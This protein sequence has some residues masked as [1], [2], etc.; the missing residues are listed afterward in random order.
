MAITA[1]FSPGTGVLSLVGDTGSSSGDN[2]RL[3]WNRG[4]GSDVM[5][6]GADI[7]AAPFDGGIGCD[8]FTITA[9]AGRVR[10]FRAFRDQ[11]RDRGQHHQ[12]RR[13]RRSSK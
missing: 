1:T 7:D 9:N 3:I 11:P 10:A 4:D 8:A 12:R 2:D 13:R 6:G 5:E